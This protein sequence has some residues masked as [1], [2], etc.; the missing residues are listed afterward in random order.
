[1]TLYLVRHGQA[2]AG[3]EDRD[4]GLSELGRAQ[5]E[6]TA[7]ALADRP[8]ARLVVSPLRR[9]RETA[10][11]L[12]KR[13]AL[14][15]ELRSEVAEVFDPSMSI[16]E[17]RAMIGPLMAGRWREQRPALLEWRQR[18]LDAVLELARQAVPGEREI[19]VVSHYIAIAAAVGA[20][21]GDDRVVP[22]EVPNCS[23]TALAWDGSG[24]RLV[25]PPS[26][27]HLPAELRTGRRTALP[28]G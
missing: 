13:F 3:I 7:A 20:A 22:M 16:E 21:L 10:E 6:R 9:T 28:G 12:A 1:M 18:A 17:R 26:D 27:A 25:Q 15:P 14:L 24:L 4:P 2:A 5:A 23:I 11:P 19:V 8:I